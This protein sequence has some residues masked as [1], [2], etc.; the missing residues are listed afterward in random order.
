MAVSAATG[1]VP[2]FYYAT[3]PNEDPSIPQE[4]GFPCQ[5][6]PVW[7]NQIVESMR[8]S[9]DPVSVVMAS[10]QWEADYQAQQP[11]DMLGATPNHVTASSATELDSWYS[12]QHQDSQSPQSLLISP[13][14]PWSTS[15]SA[16]P[17]SATAWQPSLD[18]QDSSKADKK[19]SARRR[20]TKK[21]V[22]AP[23]NQF[24]RSSG[25]Y[26]ENSEQSYNNGRDLESDVLPRPDSKKTYRTNNRAAAKRCRD[27]TR[28]HE[29]DLMAMDRHVTE[30]RMYLDACVATLQDEVLSLKNTILQHSDCGCEAIERYITKAASDV[31][32]GTKST[33][34]GSVMGREREAQTGYMRGDSGRQRFRPLNSP[35]MNAQQAT[36]LY[37]YPTGLCDDV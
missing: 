21:L 14:T 27:K 23:D 29:L 18:S 31:S 37:T 22:M 33:G 19:A 25:M 16:G 17:H 26:N 6:W 34:R 35:N 36:A 28:Q 2:V 12:Y 15:S 30:K 20:S 5:E 24:S 7:D 11:L 9:D 10:L 1:Y 4:K 8:S 13:P 32:L 3:P